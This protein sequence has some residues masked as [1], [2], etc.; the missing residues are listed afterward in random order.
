MDPTKL[1]VYE[2]KR[3]LKDR[4]LDTSGKKVFLVSRLQYA[5]DEER[6]KMC[7]N[8]ESEDDANELA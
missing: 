2:L 6:K 1:L 7:S 4:N 8:T 5:L 3:E